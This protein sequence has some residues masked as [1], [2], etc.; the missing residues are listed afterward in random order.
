MNP[1]K[2]DLG[3]SLVEILVASVVALIMILAIATFQVNLSKEN[4]AISQKIELGDLGQQLSQVLANDELC[5][6]NVRGATLEPDAATTPAAP[7]ATFHTNEISPLRSVCPVTPGAPAA[8]GEVLAEKGQVLPNSN[9]KLPVGNITVAQLKDM[10]PAS[11]AYP[12]GYRQYSGFIQI[13][14]ANDPGAAKPN[15]VRS[16]QPIRIPKI[17]WIDANQKIRACGT[18]SKDVIYKESVDAAGNPK[19]VANRK[20]DNVASTAVCPDGT[21]AIGGGWRPAPGAYLAGCEDSYAAV[22]YNSPRMEGPL[23]YKA[24][25]VLILCSPYV[26][27]AT[28]LRISGSRSP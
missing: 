28:C 19:I 20:T 18:S 2:N 22:I 16:V 21:I 7:Q 26:A 8:P 5:T 9:Y 23:A 12:G 11:A 15:L 25:D 27:Y 6:C 1:I 24:W 14:I 13:E 10:N 4:R 3:F 17:F